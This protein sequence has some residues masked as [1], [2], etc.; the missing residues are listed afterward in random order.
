MPRKQKQNSYNRRG[1]NE[2]SIFQRKDGRWV[3]Q[4]LYGYLP[5]GKPDRRYF[6]GKSHEEVSQKVTDATSKAFNGYA[7]PKK[8]DLT[9]QAFLTD[10]LNAFKKADVKPRTFEWYANLAKPLL[11]ALGGVPLKKLNAMQI[12]EF[13]NMQ[14][15]GKKVQTVKRTRDL[16]NQALTYAEETKLI[17]RNPVQHTKL[18]KA[19]RQA[20]GKKVKAIPID[21]RPKVL[22]AAEQDE[23]F[24]PVVFTLMF[25]GLRT[26]ELLGLIWRNVDFQNGV[27]VVDRAVTLDTEL[28]EDLQP[29]RRKTVTAST[30]TYNSDRTLKM[31]ET[32]KQALLDWKKQRYFG[33]E[34][35]I[36]ASRE[37]KNYTYGG[38]RAMH[39]RFLKRNGLP[40]ISLHQYRH[41]FATQL[42][43]SGVNPKIVQ[44]L[45]GHTKVETT[46]NIYSDVLKEVFDSV[47]EYI[48]DIC[49]D[50][51]SGNFAPR[52][53]QSA[54]F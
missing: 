44:K 39:R 46:L 36:F 1:N 51:M 30:K 8:H 10:W 2:G 48:D 29:V 54:N 15:E 21:T 26:G 24:K 49:A 43:E 52:L 7:P 34:S 17:E 37:K 38:F 20:G 3:G 32:V 22:A 14:V 6:Y 31:P 19:E 40:E 28:D 41:T 16:L 50:T 12:Q 18:P 9:L 11:A 5:N 4:V 33:E 23:F 35:A 45:L 53:R 25:M 42:L 13:L 27:I 47:A